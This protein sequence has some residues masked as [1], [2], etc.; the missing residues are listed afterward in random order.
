MS[1][2][3]AT[4]GDLEAPRPQ[5]L[6]TTAAIAV[7]VVLH[8][9]LVAAI[10]STS[11]YRPP[12]I[13]EQQTIHV[14]LARIGTPRDKKLLPRRPQEPAS[15]AAA[16]VPVSSKVVPIAS[17]HHV[18]LTDAKSKSSEDKLR[19]A[20]AKLQQQVDQ[21]GQ[22]DGFENGTDDVTEG[23]LYWA[24][25]VDRIKRFYVVPNTIPESE[26]KKLVADV[27]ITIGSDG[28]ILEIHTQQT[29]GNATFDHAIETAVKRCRALPPPPATLADQARQGVVLEF[30]SAEM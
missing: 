30:R 2:A 20:L 29:S 25:V 14:K 6:S 10:L 23:D 9:G 21:T 3:A 27:Q 17:T 19:N 15:Q 26:R 28:S 12:P 4:F 11:L 7:S 13:L 24:R 22:P 18:K 8:V 1:A 16:P 5:A